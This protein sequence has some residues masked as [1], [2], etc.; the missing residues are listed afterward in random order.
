[1][2]A[3]MVFENPAAFTA[4]GSADFVDGEDMFTAVAR[5]LESELLAVHVE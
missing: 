3:T 4:E 5:R 1:M 2:L